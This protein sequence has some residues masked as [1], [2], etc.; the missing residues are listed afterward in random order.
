MSDILK[1]AFR[2]FAQG[3]LGVAALL[4]VPFL[5]DLISAASGSGEV[6]VDANALQKIGI[7]AAAGGVIALVAFLQN[8]FEDKTGTDI[9]P[10]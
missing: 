3:A 7:A 4:F 6:E 8:L 1:R 2:T 10:K 9:L 5:Q